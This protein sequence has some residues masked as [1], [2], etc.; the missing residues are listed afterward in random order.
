MAIN[1]LNFSKNPLLQQLFNS[2]VSRDAINKYFTNAY[3][4]ADLGLAYDG[5]TMSDYAKKFANDHPGMSYE[6]ARFAELL[7]NPFNTENPELISMRGKYNASRG[8]DVLNDFKDASE[9]TINGTKKFWE[10]NPEFT[11]NVSLNGGSN[12][13]ATMAALGAQ[14]KA[15]PFIT[16]GT[17]ANGAMNVAGLFDNDKILGQAIGTAA[18]AIL[19]KALGMGLS[20]LAALNVAMGAGNLGAMFDIMR[21]KKEQQKY[22]QKYNMGR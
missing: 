15:H 20:P 19:P 17:A 14:A 13:G 6:D 7:N 9:E 10:S 22:K 4:A 8:A 3:N 21:S 1:P 18:G 16:A 11:D 2:Q 5:S 12:L